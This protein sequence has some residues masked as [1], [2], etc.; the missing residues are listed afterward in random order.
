MTKN[1]AAFIFLGLGF[2]LYLAP[3]LLLCATPPYTRDALVHHMAVPKIWLNSGGICEIPW[4][5]FSYHPMNLQI[6]YYLSL[7]FKSDIAPKFVHLSFALATGLIIFL[8]LKTKISKPWAAFGALFYLTVPAVLKLQTIA[9][10][11]LGLA[12]FVCACVLALFKWMEQG[13]GVNGWL[14]L[15]GVCMGLA[16]GT[17]PNGILAWGLMCL[18]VVYFAARDAEQAQWKAVWWG[19]LFFLCA[20][21][22]V[23]PWYIKNYIQVGNPLYPLFSPGGSAYPLFANDKAG[24]DISIFLLRKQLFGE[25]LLEYLLIPIRMFFSGQD[26]TPQF[27]DGVLNPLLLL[28]APF[29]FGW[30][31]HRKQVAFMGLFCLLYIIM[32]FL[33]TAPRIRYII[34]TIPFLAVMT[35]MG[36]AYLQNALSEHFNGKSAQALVWLPVLVAVLGLGVNARYLTAYFAKADPMPYVTG[37]ESRADF[38][39]KRVREYKAVEFINDSLPQDAVVMLVFMGRRGYYLDRQYFHKNMGGVREIDLAIQDMMEGK[40]SSGRLHSYGAT[41]LLVQTNLF[42]N[43]IVNEFG[44]A[45]GKEILGQ[46]LAQNPVLFQNKEY[47]VLQVGAVS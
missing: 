33:K 41:H 30:K 29:A 22:V 6:L 12:F 26:D 44:E 1:R 16:V 28:A 8:Y 42:I 18:L 17:K 36:L 38:L 34:C 37:R 21:I 15:A 3:V 35:A 27:F 23:S 40:S 43:H 4:A 45:R 39:E 47:A 20:L 2:I 25:G 13:Y 24:E 9:Y 31:K 10:V 19:G 14:I 46:F 7:V 5:D 11:D 32:A